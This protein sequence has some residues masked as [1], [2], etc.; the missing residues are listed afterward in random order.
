MQGI[1]G[2]HR[3]LGRLENIL[4]NWID[5]KMPIANAEY[6]AS[7]SEGAYY[8][9]ASDSDARVQ[10][11]FH[12]YVPGTYKL[13]FFITAQNTGTWGIK[14]YVDNYKDGVRTQHF[15]T[16]DI[17]EGTWTGTTI[18]GSE[19]LESTEFTVKEESLL[20]TCFYSNGSQACYLKI[21]YVKLN[22]Q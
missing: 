20:R 22:K 6:G 3:A 21:Q 2:I 1:E 9:P 15:P 14:L 10:L 8:L 11:S 17:I 4:R 18:E 7:I 16:G 19:V 13:E 5:P 12:V